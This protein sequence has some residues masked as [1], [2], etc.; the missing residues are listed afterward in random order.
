MITLSAKI[1]CKYCTE[2]S[3]A[4]HSHVNKMASFSADSVNHKKR[5]NVSRELHQHNN[6]KVDV[7][8]PVQNPRVEGE[9]VKYHTG[10]HPDI[11]K[12]PRKTKVINTV[13]CINFTL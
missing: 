5:K 6:Q 10:H 4:A 13:L 7:V 8:V 1:N 12:T 2:A 3:Y 11:L 9:T